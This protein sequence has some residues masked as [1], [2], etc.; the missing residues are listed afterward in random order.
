MDGICRPAT[1]SVKWGA[2]WRACVDGSRKRVVKAA[3]STPV[4]GATKAP[5]FTMSI[6][7]GDRTWVTEVCDDPGNI[8]F[9]ASYQFY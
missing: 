1:D 3:T 9:I 7:T 8:E 2:P 4:A 6:E 5:W